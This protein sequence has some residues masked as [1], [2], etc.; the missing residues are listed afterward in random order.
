MCVGSAAKSCPTLRPPRTV[1]HQT[2]LS[3][4][5]SRQ[6]YWSGLSFP[7]PTGLLDSR[8]GITSLVSP[9]LA[10]GSLYH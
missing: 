8:I 9:A 10:G 3:M 2:P 1:V 4:K 6:E 7:T 5:F